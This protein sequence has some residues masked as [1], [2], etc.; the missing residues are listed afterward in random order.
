MLTFKQGQHPTIERIKSEVGILEKTLIDLQKQTLQL[1]MIGDQT[2]SRVSMK[3]YL[4]TF[5]KLQSYCNDVNEI[6]SS[7]RGIQSSIQERRL[8]YR[9]SKNYNLQAHTTPLSSRK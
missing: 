7:E 1:H 9:A 5:A 6:Q 8:Q 4:D 2:H 3:V